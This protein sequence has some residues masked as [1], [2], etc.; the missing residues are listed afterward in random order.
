MNSR[1][2]G[3]T[4]IE[5]MV[6]IL[7]M[8]FIAGL[9]ILSLQ[10]HIDRARWT[11]S[12]DHIKQL[13]QMGRWSAR[14]DATP[15]LITYSR[16]KKKVTLRPLRDGGSK[17]NV[18]ECKLPASLE[19]ATF[20]QGPVSRQVDEMAIE[21]ASNGQSDSYAFALKAASGPVQWMVTLGLSGQHIK[22]E[23]SND[24]AALFK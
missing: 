11:K 5:L 14:R 10:G 16:S 9:A 1:A 17:R 21:I 2:N 13:D 20:Q 18:R 22:T 19:F 24:V 8:S 7:I 15:Y 23:N 12:F 3:F 4:L 6:V